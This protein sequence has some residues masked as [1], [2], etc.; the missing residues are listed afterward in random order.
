MDSP[1]GRLRRSL[2]AALGATAGALVATSAAWAHAEISPPVFQRGDG[3][4]FVLTVPT[5]KE[6]LTTT[7]VEFTPAPGLKV[8]SFAPSPG[9]KRQVQTTGSG[10]EQTVGKVTWTGGSVPEGEYAAFRF[11]AEADDSGTLA[12][13]VRQ[14][15]SDGSIVEWTGAEDSDEPAPRI[16]AVSDVGGGGGSSTLGIIALIAGVVGVLLGGAAL[17]VRGGRSLA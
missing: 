8:F 16:E 10:E 13:T 12:S 6:G 1:L 4:E 9:W 2:A 3:Y 17:L 15:Y 7:G 14:T 11:T 5:E